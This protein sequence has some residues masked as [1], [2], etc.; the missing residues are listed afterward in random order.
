MEDAHKADGTG[1][2]AT[3]GLGV[4]LALLQR[5]DLIAVVCTLAGLCVGVVLG[6]E[7]AP[8]A[9]LAVGEVRPS[10]DESAA[11]PPREAVPEAPREDYRR[12]LGRR[13]P[14]G[15]GAKGFAPLALPSRKAAQLTNKEAT[16]RFQIGAAQK[17]YALTTIVFLEG[18]KV[19][20]LQAHLD[21]TALTT[22]ALKE[23]WGIYSSPVPRP[24]LDGEKHDLTLRVDGISDTAVVGVDSVAIAPVGPSASFNFGDQGVG[25]LVDGF[26]KPSG[27]SAWSDG[28]S[29]TVGFVL[30][31][32]PKEYRLAIRGSAL[33]R[34]APL[35]VTAK[36]NGKDLG[37]AQFEKRTEERTWSVPANTLVP[38]LNRIEFSYPA[39]ARPSEYNPKS[40]DKRALALRFYD[41]SLQPQ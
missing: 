34:L 2:N 35:T 21:G 19:G 37:T 26:S 30:A 24:L 27:D 17:D 3:K 36:V 31:P 20:T 5:R 7:T 23:G 16:L 39:T 10:K 14:K 12:H 29:S 38:G 41:L 6:R 15:D 40:N 33:S 32:E 11:P 22:V 9:A 4:G 25:T 18:S 1:V 13:L 8:S 28:D